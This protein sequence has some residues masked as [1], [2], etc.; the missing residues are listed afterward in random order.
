MTPRTRAVLL[1]RAVATT[2]ASSVGPAQAWDGTAWTIEPSPSP[3]TDS[4][5]VGVSCP[6]TTSCL[7]A[8]SYGTSQPDVSKTL[9]ELG[10]LAG[11]AV[12]GNP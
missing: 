10:T 7:A 1:A 9:V 5:L 2:V 4:G 11:T 8:G 6:A 12:G 3:G